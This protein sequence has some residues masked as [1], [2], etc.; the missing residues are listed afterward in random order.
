MTFEVKYFELILL[1]SRVSYKSSEL[2]S[3][4]TFFSYLVYE[5]NVFWVPDFY[6]S[7]LVSWFWWSKKWSFLDPPKSPK[8]LE[9]LTLAKWVSVKYLGILRLIIWKWLTLKW[10][11]S[12]ILHFEVS[13]FGE[14][15]NFRRIAVIPWEKPRFTT[16]T[17][18]KTPIRIPCAG[19]LT[20]VPVVNRRK[21]HLFPA[22][23]Q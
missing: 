22:C 1:I 13:Y 20:A 19:V 6:V 10:I 15:L 8:S 5:K 23:S 12:K 14:L 4:L 17:A 2:W 3:I 18:V 16:E 7:R 9:Y 11:I 21:D